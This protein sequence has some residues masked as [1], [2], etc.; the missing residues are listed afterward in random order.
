[1]SSIPKSHPLPA[2][3]PDREPE[4]PISISADRDSQQTSINDI[5]LRAYRKFAHGEPI[6]EAMSL[7]LGETAA[8]L[9]ANP[10][11]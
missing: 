5:V 6:R 2:A 11:P 3:S 7:C 1:M 9:R 4:T 8:S 10:I